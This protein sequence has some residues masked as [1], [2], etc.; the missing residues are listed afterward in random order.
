MY[1][2]IA[3]LLLCCAV[4]LLT[5]CPWS[6]N[7]KSTP[8]AQQT[9]Y[10]AYVEFEREREE[11]TIETME[12]LLAVAQGCD[13]DSCRQGIASNGFVFLAG[14]SAGGR[15]SIAPPVAPPPKRSGVDI[16]F[17][18]LDRAIGYVSGER[19]ARYALD[20]TLAMYDFL[21]G[22]VGDLSNSPA[23]R[24][25]NITVGN[26]WVQGN[27]HHGDAVGRDQIAGT[28]HIGDTV[29]GDQAGRDLRN[30]N[31]T[32]IRTGNINT[33]TQVDNTGVIGSGRQNSP[34]RDIGNQGNRCDGEDCQ[35][36][37]PPPPEE[38]DE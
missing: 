18:F 22:A 38:S 34:D 19:S 25:P 29:G 7:V 9:D 14:A 4:L 27:Q 26:D 37:Q 2:A 30:G 1:R 28:Q 20:G 11:R 13:S 31:D 3:M 5:G 17:G 35:T 21:G 32:R 16:A 15:R 10:G 36:V 24:A 12:K 33:G 6:R 23:L 8:G